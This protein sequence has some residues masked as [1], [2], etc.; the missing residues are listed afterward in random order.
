[1]NI[2]GPIIALIAANA[3]A[4]ALLGGRVYPQKLKQ[5]TAYPA[6]AIN[7]TDTNPNN[8]KTGPSDMDRVLVQID[9]YASNA[10][11]AAEAAEAIRVA[12][13]YQGSGD[14]ECIFFRRTLDGLSEKPELIRKLTEYS[15]IYRR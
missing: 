3:P 2:T 7:V 1:M 14:I 10:T 6:A 9:V 4:N 8:T 11:A 13:D 12:I 5:S 15:I